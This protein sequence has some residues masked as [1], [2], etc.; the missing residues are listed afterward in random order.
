MNFLD[1]KEEKMSLK[2]IYKKILKNKNFKL[3]NVYENFYWKI[4]RRMKKKEKK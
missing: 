4:K 2:N 1:F 3:G